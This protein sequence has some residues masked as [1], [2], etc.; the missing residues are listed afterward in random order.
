MAVPCFVVMKP[1]VFFKLRRR[2]PDLHLQQQQHPCSSSK[3]WGTLALKQQQQSYRLSRARRAF[4]AKAGK[5]NVICNT[6]HRITPTP[7][8]WQNHD[9][10]G[11]TVALPTKNAK[12]SV[13]LVIKMEIPPWR[14]VMMM[15]SSTVRDGLPKAARMYSLLKIGLG[16]K[17][18]ENRVVC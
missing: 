2:M 1:P 12:A 3:G 15:F 4:N 10:A 8:N 16:M 6:K 5:N 13:A 14:A 9:N 11:S 18:V 17:F 7:A